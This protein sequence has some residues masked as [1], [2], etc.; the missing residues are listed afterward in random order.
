M[1]ENN[2]T[3]RE[4][5]EQILTPLKA[6]LIWFVLLVLAIIA[7]YKLGVYAEKIGALEDIIFNQEVKN[8]STQK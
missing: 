3:I 4:K 5:T 7:S 8:V 6:D 1:T 2:P